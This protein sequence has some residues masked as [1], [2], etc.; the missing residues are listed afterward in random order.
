MGIAK[1]ICDIAPAALASRIFGAVSDRAL[2]P[3]AQRF[4]NRAFARLAGINADESALPVEDYKTLNALFTRELKPDAR[5]ISCENADCAASPADGR[6]SE[7]GRV[8]DGML[9]DVK[10]RSYSAEELCCASS[11]DAETAWIR[12][13][14]AMTIYLSP[15][16]YHR[17]HAPVSGAVAQMRYAP[18]R[19]LPVNR[20][21]YALTD[22]LLPKN[23]RLTSFIEAENGMRVAVVKVGATCVGRI[24]VVYDD[25]KTNISP[26]CEPFA[27]RI[28]P[29]CAVKAGAPLGCFELGSTVVLLFENGKKTFVPDAALRSGQKIM[30]GAPIG[31]WT[32]P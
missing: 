13:A 22:D 19:L 10:G 23:E 30:L 28:D 15:R 31:R 11:A 16:D 4:V 24:S 21:G 9:L 12:N 8:A 27:K 1:K 6:L 14:F 26:K 3:P 18:G 5:P 20:L 29:P 7:L 25:F 17:I 2:F 32:E